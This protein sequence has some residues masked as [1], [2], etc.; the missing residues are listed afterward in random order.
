MSAKLSE[1]EKPDEE[2]DVIVQCVRAVDNV[3]HKPAPHWKP[4][5]VYIDGGK[6]AAFETRPEALDCAQR[7]AQERHVLAWKFTDESGYQ[8][9]EPPRQ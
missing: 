8:L 1:R 5:G 2:R 3:H 6:H 4:W 7:V 9:L